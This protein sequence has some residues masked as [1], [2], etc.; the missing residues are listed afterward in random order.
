MPFLIIL[1][2]SRRT[3]ISPEAYGIS[4]LLIINPP[5]LEYLINPIVAAHPHTKVQPYS[6]GYMLY[7][8][9]P[10]PAGAVYTHNRGVRWDCRSRSC[11]HTTHICGA[12]LVRHNVFSGCDCRTPSVWFTHTLASAHTLHL[13][14]PGISTAPKDAPHLYINIIVQQR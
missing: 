2:V 10:A 8:D 5:T 3:I 4:I 6:P 13:C 7:G 11:P 1:I 9:T 14:S 12:F